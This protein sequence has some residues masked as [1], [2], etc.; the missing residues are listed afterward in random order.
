VAIRT[1]DGG[2]ESDLVVP[3]EVSK[4]IADF[5]STMTGQPAPLRQ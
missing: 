2:I 3:F 4:T 5:V 1:T